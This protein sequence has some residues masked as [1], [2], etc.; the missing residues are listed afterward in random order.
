MSRASS[1][2]RALERSDAEVL[3]GDVFELVGFVED[4]GRGFREDAGVGCAR[5]L[6]LDGERSAKKRWWL[7]MTMSDLEGLATHLGDEAGLPVGAG[8]AEA[9][10]AAGVEFMPER[11]MLGEVF[12][13][14]AVTGFGGALPLQDGVNCEISSR[15]V[16]KGLSRRA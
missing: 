11:G 10:F 5:G 14:G 15:P 8:L 4:Y 12:D 16:S 1:S 9:D 2:K 6:L 7:T 13:F 3:A